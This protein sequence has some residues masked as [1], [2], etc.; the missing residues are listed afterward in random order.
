MEADYYKILGVSPNADTAQIKTRYRF[1]CNA[2]HPDKFPTTQREQAEEE[3]KPINRAYQV[4]SIEK[5]RAAYDAARRHTST[6]TSQRETEQQTTPSSQSQ[7][8]PPKSASTTPKPMLFIG[9]AHKY[10]GVF[11]LLSP[12]RCKLFLSEE[13]LR[14]VDRD[15]PKYSFQI[16]SPILM[17]ASFQ[18]RKR[19]IVHELN[20]LLPDGKEY[21][22]GLS[23]SEIDRVLDI[24]R[25]LKVA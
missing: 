22:I 21:K 15:E 23:E 17:K 11:A 18:K 16:S 25:K 13:E 19:L 1:L 3:F 8:N 4:L 14:F 7:P 24:I 20:I 6:S 12:S 2:F 5:K 9:H 10:G